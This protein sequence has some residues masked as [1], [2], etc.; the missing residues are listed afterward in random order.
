MSTSEINTIDRGAGASQAGTGR[1]LEMIRRIQ[2]QVSGNEPAS[3][4]ALRKA[5]LERFTALGF[6]TVEQEEWRYT[7]VSAI[8]RQDFVL[9]GRPEISSEEIDGYRLAEAS[10]ELVFLNGHFS[11]AHSRNAGQAG[12]QVRDFTSALHQMPELVSSHVGQVAGMQQ[13]AFRAL[14]AA[15]MNTGAVIVTDDNALVDGPI[16]LLFMTTANA[17]APSPIVNPR[18][19]VIAR[20]SSRI[21]VVETWAGTGSYFN[22]PVTELIAGPSAGITHDKVI[23]ESG[24]SFHIASLAVRQ[25]RDSSVTSSVITLGGGLVRNEISVSLAGEGS[26]VTLDGLYVTRGTQHVDNQ[27]VIDHQKPHCTS[28][29]HYKGILDG[30]SRGIFDGKIIVRKDAQKTS[31][32]Q[33][34]NNLILSESATVDTKPQLE[35]NNDDVKC[36]H[37]STIGR[38]D[39][40]ALFYLRSRALDED[41]AR[42][43]LTYAF[44]SEIVDRLKISSLRELL[45]RELTG[46]LPQRRTEKRS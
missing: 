12:A 45:Q 14:N 29:E 8:A 35:I 27:T 18:N 38:L 31:S 30:R 3:V 23:R 5:A 6:P 13:H 43:L 34:N 22:N 46:R 1:F 41:Q 21:H 10:V 37:G 40:D 28:T 2:P 39:E 17:G 36:S 24:E 33:T 19:L 16:H 26:S 15:L 7:N 44:A 25:E 42:A 20:R 4:F 9:A 32:R 11:A